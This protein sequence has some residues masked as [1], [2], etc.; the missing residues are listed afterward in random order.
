MRR[1][2]VVIIA[3][4]IIGI[5]ALI[6]AVVLVLQAQTS[7]V[8]SDEPL[9]QPLPSA[10][11]Q[12]V[13]PT[14]PGSVIVTSVPVPTASL[15]PSPAPLPSAAA[16]ALVAEPFTPLVYDD[17]TQI[18]SGWAVIYLDQRGNA[19]GYS[20]EGYMF[21][22]SIPQQVLYDVRSDLPFQ[23]TRVVAEIRS[24]Q[25]SGRFGLMFDVKGDPNNYT[26]LAYYAIVVSSTGEVA[27]LQ[28]LPG[29]RLPQIVQAGSRLVNLPQFDRPLILE[30][31]RESSTLTVHVDGQE[32]LRSAL[33]TPGNGRV[34]MLTLADET[35]R[36]HFDN[37]LFSTMPVRQGPLCADLRILFNTLDPAQRF[38]DEDVALVQMRLFRLG[39]DPG[40]IDGIFGNLTASAVKT[41]QERNGLISDGVVG[42]DTWCLLLSS[43]AIRVDSLTERAENRVRFRS[44][45]ILS[46]IVLPAP[47]MVSVRG[48]DQLW[49]IGL[50]LPGKDEIR[51]IDT[52]GDAF[53][54]AWSPR[55]GLLAFTSLRTNRELGS[56]WIL[57]TLTGNIESISLPGFSSQFPTWSPDGN[58]LIYTA[59]LPDGG[60]MSA[61]IFRYDL[62]TRQ[63]I[64]LSDE[65]AGWSDWSLNDRLVFARWTGQSFDVFVANSDGSGEINLTN[66]DEFD[67][68]IPAW[69]PD[70]ELIALVRHPRSNRNDRQ[71]FVMRSDGTDLRQITFMPGPNSNPIWMDANTIVFANQPNDQIRQPYIVDLAG[72]VRQLIANEDRIWFMSRMDFK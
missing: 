37:L 26:S 53:D 38:N 17:F 16:E 63:N 68:D 19:N 58:A 9:I 20:A 32:V 39:Y 18:Q 34:G 42:P 10:T 67:E 8:T 59:E 49:Q 46:G 25:G 50:V 23:P 22:A 60:S 15:S 45:K 29:D 64:Q 41:F 52:Q 24:V 1:T 11:V 55:T 5:L 4:S 44:V 21:D 66:T 12:L 30:I 62:A 43:D 69:S 13:V 47:L 40:P 31:Q 35:L 33:P 70:G 65:H 72:N 27:L 54:P 2:T 57:N 28:Q 51:Y 61:R 7:I 36:V 14:E 3:V 48:P 6:S 56:I 71:I